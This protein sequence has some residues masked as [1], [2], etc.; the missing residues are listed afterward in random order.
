[1][2]LMIITIEVA[3]ELNNILPDN[4]FI[5]KSDQKILESL[6]KEKRYD[7]FNKEVLDIIGRSG[8]TDYSLLTIEDALYT[9]KEEINRFSEGNFN[10]SRL[11]SSIN[12]IHELV[13]NKESIDKQL[14]DIFQGND[15]SIYKY[16]A[17]RSVEITEQFEVL[18]AIY[19]RGF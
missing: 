4:F 2:Y 5:N 19:S 1:M 17:K 12:N 9:L 11:N 18:G 7:E 6:Y 13:K 16:Q 10:M 8:D 15:V 14:G 3:M